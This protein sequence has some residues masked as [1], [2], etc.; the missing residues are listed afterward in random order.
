[1]KNILVMIFVF[2]LV[3]SMNAAVFAQDEPAKGDKAVKDKIKREK[4][5]G[6]IEE[7]EELFKDDPAYQKIL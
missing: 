1:M 6:E 4:K 2:V 5:V 7:L 3:F